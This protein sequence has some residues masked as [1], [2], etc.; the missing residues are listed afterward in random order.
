MNDRRL[1]RPCL[2]L[3]TVLVIA[4]PGHLAAQSARVSAVA[5]L[6]SWEPPTVQ[7]PSPAPFDQPRID[8]IDVTR[9]ILGGTLGLTAGFGVASVLVMGAPSV[10][11]AMLTGILAS[12]LL[13]PYGTALGA[14]LGNRSRGNFT[15]VLL[16]TGAGALA[17]TLAYVLMDPDPL[18]PVILVIPV[19]TIGA[20][21]VTEL[22]T[23][24]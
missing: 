3:L 16:A 14:H 11:G 6:E 1:I 9:T 8:G 5:H 24:R 17:S 10:E 20:A 19:T 12:A 21:V 2:W 18:T 22:L 7:L 23:T 15:G 4:L 13:I